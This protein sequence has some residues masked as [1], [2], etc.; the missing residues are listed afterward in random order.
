MSRVATA[1]GNA[2]LLGCRSRKL[3][4]LVEGCRRGPME[5]G[6]HRHL[7][8]L[9]VHTAA[10]AVAR[11]VHAQKLVYFARDFLAD[12]FGRFFSCSVCRSG[13]RERQISVLVW[14]NSRL[15]C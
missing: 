14:T 5:G 4:Q 9:Q 12:R 8:G 15:S 1:A 6:A 7:D 10:L 13:S 11:Q 2:P 3:Q